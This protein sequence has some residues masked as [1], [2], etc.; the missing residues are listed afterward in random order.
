MLSVL[1]P[2][3][4]S[5]FSKDITICRLP[6]VRCISCFLSKCKRAEDKNHGLMLLR[7][8]ATLKFRFS[9]NMLK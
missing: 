8:L 6:I 2:L 5:E 1:K 7:R 9:V 4:L 3:N